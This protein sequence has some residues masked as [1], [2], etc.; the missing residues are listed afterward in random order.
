MAINFRLA[1]HSLKP[2]VKLIEIIL[3]GAVV[4][5]IY[6]NEERDGIKIVSAHF[7]EKDIPEKFDGEVIEES[8]EGTFSPI[9]VVRITFKPRK[10]IIRRGKIEYLE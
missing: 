8:G 1:R 5:T 4:G 10:Y 6:P 7:F 2:E 9:P 3:N